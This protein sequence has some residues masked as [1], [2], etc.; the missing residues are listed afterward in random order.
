MRK[1][2]MAI[3]AL[4]VVLACAVGVFADDAYI[5]CTGDPVARIVISVN[6]VHYGDLAAKQ[7]THD[8]HDVGYGYKGW[9]TVYVVNDSDTPWSDFHFSLFQVV[10]P[11]GATFKDAGMGGQNPV[12][13][14]NGVTKSATWTIDNGAVGGPTLD[15]DFNNFVGIGDMAMFKVYTDNTVT[16]TKFGL[17]MYPTSD[18]VPEPSSVLALSTALAGL[19]GMVVRRKR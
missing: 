8:D 12:Y 19:V 16:N 6:P 15:L 14:L 11:F 18:Y 17:S 10:A 4:G 9:A 3:A 2:V 5:G 1:I 7:Y 13:Q